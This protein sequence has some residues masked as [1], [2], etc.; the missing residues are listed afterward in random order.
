MKAK[1]GKRTLS[2]FLAL[3]LCLSLLPMTALAG[4]GD[5]NV[6]YIAEGGSAVVDLGANPVQLK[7]DGDGAYAFGLSFDFPEGVYT[8]DNAGFEQIVL[9]EDV[10]PAAEAPASLVLYRKESPQIAR[11][12]FEQAGDPYFS[13]VVLTAGE[14]NSAR[15]YYVE[16]RY[17]GTYFYSAVKL[18]FLPSGAASAPVIA[19]ASLNAG[20]V[21]ISYAAALKGSAGDGTPL[22]WSVSGGS[23]PSGLTLN[24]DTG[25][26]SGTPHPPSTV[27]FAHGCIGLP[28]RRDFT[29]G[30]GMSVVHTRRVASGLSST[31]AT[32]PSSTG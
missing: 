16:A 24:A 8:A 4:G 10:N 2:L 12:A 19:T 1:P 18:Q 15:A 3:V 25:V 11:G 28:L 14:V 17:A 13:G 26:I 30:T 21:G 7:A 29:G 5:I 9:W 22:T 32:P 20:T 27:A 23:Q 31:D 6:Y